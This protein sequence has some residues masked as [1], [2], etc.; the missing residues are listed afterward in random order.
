MAKDSSDIDPAMR[1]VRA[2]AMLRCIPTNHTVAV[3][4]DVCSQGACCG[5]VG[6]RRK[7]RGDHLSR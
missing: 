6:A 1:C 5:G 2:A 4:G 3:R 7:H